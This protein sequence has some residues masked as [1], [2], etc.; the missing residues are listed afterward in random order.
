V[1]DHAVL[2][3]PSANRVYA[4]QGPR[5]L[6]A[7]LSALNELALGGA[8]Q[9]IEVSELAGIPY[10]TFAGSLSAPELAVV[11]NLS[12]AYALF[13]RDGATLHPIAMR[14][15][16][17][18]DDDLVTI[19]RYSGKTNEQLTRLL[20]NLTIA[21]VA[22]AAAFTGERKLRVLDPLCG[23]GTTLNVA[24]LCGQDAAGVDIDKR[25]IDAYVHFF[26]TW[27]KDK[28]A[29]HSTRRSG[30]RTTITFARDK[31]SQKRGDEQEVVVTAGET[32]DA[33]VQLGKAS[34][35]AIVTDLPYGV[36]HGSHSAGSL[37]RSPG[38]LLDAALPVWRSIL[39]NNGAIGLAWNTRV[40]DRTAVT[41]ALTRAGLAVVTG[42]PF[43][44][45]THRVDQ[46]V[47]RDV[48][49]ARRQS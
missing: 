12:T 8:L 21:A 46:A 35:D 32:T 38:D 19:Q 14:R 39:R 9:D 49:V 1:A 42:E 15:L 10:V 18:W 13:A 48:V 25:D 27:L 31:E 26:T 43:E 29:K 34:V 22:G 41:E 4:Q 17:R 47:A 16:D 36:Q 7:E 3:L 33:V 45:F 23:R 20:L 44:A 11:S 37:H 28:R 40:L 6:A 30:A 5:L 24:V 2:V